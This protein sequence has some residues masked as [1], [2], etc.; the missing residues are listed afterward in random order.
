[1]NT[2]NLGIVQTNDNKVLSAISEDFSEKF[3]EDY[4][5]QQNA[6]PFERSNVDLSIHIQNDESHAALH[7][8]SSNDSED[9]TE[10]RKSQDFKA[11]ENNS[12]KVIHAKERMDNKASTLV[13]RRLELQAE[14]RD[15]IRAAKE[16]KKAELLRLSRER[17][18]S[19]QMMQK[20]GQA[21]NDHSHSFNGEE[22]YNKDTIPSGLFVDRVNTLNEKTTEYHKISPKK[23]Y[24]I[25]DADIRLT[26]LQVMQS[27]ILAEEALRLG[28]SEFKT[29]DHLTKLDTKEMLFHEK[30][31]L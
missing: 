11:K 18:E 24:L 27:I 14:A 3:T 9:S 20:Y 30:M 7:E 10:L 4:E 28:K 25:K 23:R 26:D 21:R 2:N 12:E 31:V 22:I 15:E 1:M 17:K 29:V 5:E 19:R 6:F 16:V 13:A 8:R